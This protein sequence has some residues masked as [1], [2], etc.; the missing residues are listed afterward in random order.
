MSRRDSVN[1]SLPMSKGDFE[2]EGGERRANET[3][4]GRAADW[5]RQ[6]RKDVG[7]GERQEGKDAGEREGY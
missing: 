4:E 7:K 1:C 3:M 6:R 5:T 2:R